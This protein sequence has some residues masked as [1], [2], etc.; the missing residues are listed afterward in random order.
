MTHFEIF[1]GKDGYYF[2]LVDADEQAILVSRAYPSRRSANEGI[3]SIVENSKDKSVFE[4]KTTKSG[5]HYFVIKSAK[6]GKILGKSSQY[7]SVTGREW[8]I[9]KVGR[10]QAS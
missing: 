7:A 5:K 6:N 9:I 4:R 10:A 3:K 2:R 1:K 8:S